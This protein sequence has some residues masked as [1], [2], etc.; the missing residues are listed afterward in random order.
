[1]VATIIIVAALA[2]Y[3]G[4]VIYKQVKNKGKGCCGSDDCH[5]AAHPKK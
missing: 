5:C 4:Y 2:S 1:M 3:A